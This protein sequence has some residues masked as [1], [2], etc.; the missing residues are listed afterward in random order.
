[1]ILE[2]LNEAFTVELSTN[3]HGFRTCLMP[4]NILHSTWNFSGFCITISRL[5]EQIFTVQHMRQKNIG[6]I[7]L[8]S[9]MRTQC[10]I[11]HQYSFNGFG[12]GY[13]H[14]YSTF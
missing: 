9:L 14:K 4:S 13:A 7:Y 3:S 2:L 6:N 1:M 11:T 12:T 8:T 10:E 5:I